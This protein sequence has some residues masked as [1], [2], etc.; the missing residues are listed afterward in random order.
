MRRENLEDAQLLHRW[1]RD[2]DE[3]LRWLQ[4][5]APLAAAPSVASSLAHA[6]NLQKKHNALEVELLARFVTIYL[7]LKYINLS[8]FNY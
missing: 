2:A 7:F 4:E 3:E 8:K 1:T 6:H 5:K